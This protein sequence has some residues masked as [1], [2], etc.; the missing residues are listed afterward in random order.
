[1]G[2]GGSEREGERQLGSVEIVRR[3]RVERSQNGGEK[4]RKGR[5]KEGGEEGEERGREEGWRETYD[6]GN[7]VTVDEISYLATPVG[8]PGVL[9]GGTVGA[10]M[11][12]ERE[13]REGG[14]KGER[15]R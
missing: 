6:G 2:K 11:R 12:R 3:T 13:R 4:E 14:E 8:V 15:K 5:D 1:M 7:E 9:G 10:V